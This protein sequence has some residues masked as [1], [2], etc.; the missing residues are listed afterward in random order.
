MTAINDWTSINDGGRR[1][2]LW[3]GVLVVI[4]LA[5]ALAGT[6]L[7]PER[8]DTD[9]AHLSLRGSDTST[10]SIEGFRSAHFGADEQSVRHAIA[11]DFGKAG[12]D[13]KTI[14]TPV[15]RTRVLVLRA[16]DLFPGAGEAELGYVLG[17]KS[18]AL[19]QVNVLWGT[20]VTP[21][22]TAAQLAKVSVT[23]S[24]YFGGQGF[25]PKEIIRNRRL[26][27][28]NL[29]V[30][31]GT[32]ARGALVQLASHVEAPAN[33]PKRMV[34]RLSYIA[35]PKAPDTFHIDKGAF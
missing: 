27:G 29:L 31:Q 11:A 32:D 34:L 14:D 21:D 23:L 17:Y 3:R 1:K 20:P 33:G 12:T 35:D 19:V 30:F 18:K 28:G 7:L 2:L 16:K 15:E 4:G 8:K 25:A 26:G 9:A 6:L 5:V 24:R 13:I 10:A 22:V